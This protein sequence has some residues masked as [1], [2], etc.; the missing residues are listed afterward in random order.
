M[1]IF[2]KNVILTLLLCSWVVFAQKNPM[3]DVHLFQTFLKDAPIPSSLFGEVGLDFSDYSNSTAFELGIQGGLPINPQFEIAAK[4]GLRNLNPDGG[5]SI[6][7]VSDVTTVAVYNI[8]PGLSPLSIGGFITIPVGKKDVGEG[9]LNFGGFASVR[10][11]LGTTLVLTGVAGLEFLEMEGYDVRFENGL[12]IV[13]E[14]TD[15]ETSLLLG[16]GFIFPLNAQVHL[17]NELNIWSENDYLLV[18]SGI[19]YQL[20]S[21]ARV[22]VAL[23]IGLGDGAPDAK[24]MGSYF[25]SM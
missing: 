3:D 21:L 9:N 24:I 4:F 5:N 7:G 14:K 2:S 12:P 17:V 16:G 11:S 8:T 15:Y 10:H 1:K 22:R 19:D 6:S 18:S 13:T 20:A 25:V 23:G